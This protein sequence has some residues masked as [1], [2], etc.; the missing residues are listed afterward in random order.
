MILDIVLGVALVV[1]CLCIAYV[2]VLISRLKTLFRILLYKKEVTM[3]K[4]KTPDMSLAQL[5]RMI[6][7]ATRAARDIEFLLR[8]KGKKK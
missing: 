7:D 5:V 2:L 1:I 4:I 3:P 8:P 6:R